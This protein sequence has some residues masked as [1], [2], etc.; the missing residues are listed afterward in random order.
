LVVVS[1]LAMEEGSR[2]SRFEGTT[3]PCAASRTAAGFPSWAST[4][5]RRAGPG[6]RSVVRQPPAVVGSE[7][8]LGQGGAQRLAVD[9]SERRV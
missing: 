7:R 5:G 1:A 9:G 4:T 3:L 8:R 6:C 2:S